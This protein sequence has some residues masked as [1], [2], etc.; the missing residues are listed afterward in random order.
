MRFAFPVILVAICL[1]ASAQTE[2]EALVLSRV[3]DTLCID[4]VEARD[5]CETV[6]LLASETDPDA[7]D[8]I[9]VSDRRSQDPQATLAVV[10]NIAFSGAWYGQS[11]TL[12]IS[13]EGLLLLHEEQIAIGR[14]PWTQTLTIAHDADGFVVTEQAY[15]TYDRAVG[16]S[17]SCDVNFVSGEW[18][19]SAERPNPET[20]EIIYDVAN[21]GRG[22]GVRHALAEWN[23]GQGLPIAC[24]APL[25]AW[26]NA[27]NP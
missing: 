27:G 24:E 10:R 7:A 25:N 18:S 2:A 14:S 17:F 11:P 6:A 5:G 12:E 20:E 3:I 22:A 1:P 21:A 13:A 26:F 4:M 8:L 15:S 16:G 9:I 19:H 23:W